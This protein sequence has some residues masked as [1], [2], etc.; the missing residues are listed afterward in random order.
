MGH[1]TNFSLPSQV[2]QLESNYIHFTRLTFYSTELGTAHYVK[3][4]TKKE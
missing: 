3:Y 1:V 4:I 2:C